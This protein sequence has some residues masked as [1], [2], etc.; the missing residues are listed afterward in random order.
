MKK[1]VYH[2]STREETG[3]PAAYY[4]GISTNLGNEI[5]P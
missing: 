5:L 2:S 3:P 1:F 4:I